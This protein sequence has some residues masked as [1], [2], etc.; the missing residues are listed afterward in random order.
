MK[1]VGGLGY[2][3]DKSSNRVTKINLRAEFDLGCGCCGENVCSEVTDQ[4]LLCF[5]CFD[6]L[7]V[8]KIPN[9]ALKGDGLIAIRDLKSLRELD[10][11]LNPV[12]DD[13]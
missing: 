1:A 11:S 7:E 2:T 12:D 6:A 3:L 13:A 4:D 10:L 8:L 5:G 9:A